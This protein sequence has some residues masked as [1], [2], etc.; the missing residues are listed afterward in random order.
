MASRMGRSDVQ[1]LERAGRGWR[2]VLPAMMLLAVGSPECLRAQDNFD[3]QVYRSATVAPK[4][5]LVELMS[6]ITADGTKDLSQTVYPVT[7]LYPTDDALP[8]R[9]WRSG[10]GSMTGRRWVSMF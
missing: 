2:R 1:R 4:T 3:I 9:R 8:M 10:R 7:Q 6:N 5:T